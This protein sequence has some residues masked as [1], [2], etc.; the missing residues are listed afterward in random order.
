M[1][2]LTYFVRSSVD[3]R[4]AGREG[5]L[6]WIFQQE[7][8]VAADFIRGVDTVLMG[9]ATYDYMLAHGRSAFPGMANYVFSRT[10]RQAEHPAVTMVPTDPTPFVSSLKEREGRGIWL[11]GGGVVFR[12][13]LLAGLVDEVVVLLHPL[14]LGQGVPL[15]GDCDQVTELVFREAEPLPGGLVRLAYDV[16]DPKL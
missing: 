10:L 3:G 5:I 7:D 13:L 14:L 1:R 16:G 8:E 4:I 6:D 15:L 12:Y 9:T 2:K 11:L